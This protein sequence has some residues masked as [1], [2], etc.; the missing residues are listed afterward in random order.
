MLHR[1]LT[2]TFLD[3]APDVFLSGPGKRATGGTTG[4]IELLCTVGRLGSTVYGSIL[5]PG[6]V[7]TSSDTQ[8]RARVD[9]G[10]MVKRMAAYFPF[11]SGWEVKR[12]VKVRTRRV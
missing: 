5:R 10:M 2:A 11:G 1:V 6:G 4:G 9:L 8:A 7:I 3:I 12:D